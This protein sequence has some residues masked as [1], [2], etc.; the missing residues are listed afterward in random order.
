MPFFGERCCVAGL[1]VDVCA[2][3]LLGVACSNGSRSFNDRWRAGGASTFGERCRA[4]GLL[5]DVCTH[6]TYSLR[7]WNNI[8]IASVWKAPLAVW[9]GDLPSAGVCDS[10]R[11]RGA[12]IVVFWF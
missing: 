1:L 6:R 8:L 7:W 5:V 3:A 2:S 4:A 10:A 9:R 12:G 11:L